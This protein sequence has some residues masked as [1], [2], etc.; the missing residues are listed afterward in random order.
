MQPLHRHRPGFSL[1]E[2]L[3]VV[4]VLSIVAAIAV[5]N[6]LEAQTRSKVARTKADFRA[7]ATAL[8]AYAAEAGTYPLCNAWGVSGARPSIAG[9][10]PVLERLSTPV[11]YMTNAVPRSPFAAERYSGP[12]VVG[13]GEVHTAVDEWPRNDLGSPDAHLFRG[14]FYTSLHEDAAT[15]TGFNRA[16]IDVIPAERHAAAAW[17]LQSPGPIEAVVNMGGV[18]TNAD[19]EFACQ[20]VYDPTNGTSSFGNI[21]R[22]GGAG[23]GGDHMM[24]F[25]AGRE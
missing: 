19:A 23:R 14:H 4:A 25:L 16:R 2:I 10:P 17:V 7:L 22:V 24:G 6:M 1:I 9:D 21:F 15:A 18:T 3:V 13:L 5:P 20:L 12:H 11:A 8:E